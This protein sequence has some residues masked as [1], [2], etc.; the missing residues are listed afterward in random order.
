MLVASAASSSAENLRA[1]TSHLLAF[2]VRIQV[3]TSWR[4]IDRAVATIEAP[5]G[6]T[7]VTITQTTSRSAIEALRSAATKLPP[8]TARAIATVIPLPPKGGWIGRTEFTFSLS[9]AERRTAKAI[10][11]QGARSWTIVVLDGSDATISK[12]SAEIDE[13]LDGL[14][15]A[16][17][18]E[19]NLAGIKAHP[20]KAARVHMLKAFVKEAMV[21]LDVPG[22]ALS[23][24]SDGKIVF[25]GGLGVES[26]ETKQPV[27]ADTLFM[28]ASNTK[29]LTTLMLASLVATGDLAWD[30]PVVDILPS[31]RL[32]DEATTKRVLV[33][34]LVCAC[35][36]LP[37]KDY[38]W[39][40]KGGPDTPATDTFS[41]LANTKPT[42]D[43]GKVFQY[44]NL[45]ASA[46]G[47]IG[48]HRLYPDL[49]FGAA[50]DRAMQ[51]RVFDPLGMTST[52]FSTERALASKHASPHGLNAEGRPAV[53]SLGLNT[54]IT[55]YRPAGGAWSNVRDMTR[56]VLAE[57]S[58]G[59]AH[60]GRQV[61]A[62]DAVKARRDRIVPSGRGMWY[63][64]GLEEIDV[65]GIAVYNH[66]GSLPG[67]TSNVFFIPSANVGAVILTNSSSGGLLLEPT[68]RR[69]IELLYDRR[70]EAAAEITSAAA[71]LKSR[72][73]SHQSIT[74]PADPNLAGL[75]AQRY[76]NADLGSINVVRREGK[77]IFDFGAWSSEVGTKKNPDGTI[78]FKTIDPGVD[79]F[80]FILHLT[81]SIGTLSIF[82]GQHQYKYMQKP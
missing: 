27:D 81:K 26:I 61:I 22:V 50:Y 25:E 59:K 36:G 34:H 66:G 6:D 3:P 62:A 82:E 80:E 33:R 71:K 12:R 13:I 54:A 47:Y 17:Y 53:S 70:P 75:L 23:V 55:P 69:L 29:P 19:E 39:I 63:G 43:F 72:H 46:G 48:G 1:T 15:T 56:Y 35:T 64:I 38:G 65:S 45:M 30:E 10:V 49:E 7:V 60:D 28:I 68:M 42:S 37:R 11:F 9:P 21:A 76:E 40:F 18:Q 31:F 16:D 58:L 57:L 2:G 79:R 20:F 52:T 5:E 67:Y 73:S 78:L 4:V 77:T 74:V 24:I 14:Q 51:E 32:G 8:V 41:Q 44:S